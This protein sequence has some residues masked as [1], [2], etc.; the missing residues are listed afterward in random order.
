MPL[1]VRLV[2]ILKRMTLYGLVLGG[3]SGFLVTLTILLVPA[4]DRPTFYGLPLDT[5]TIILGGV[6][7]GVLFGTIAGFTSGFGM[8]LFTALLFREVNDM[9]RFRLMMGS[10]TL[11]L[12]VAT[13]VGRGLW[14]FGT[15]VIDPTTWQVTMVMSVLIAMYASQRVA[16]KYL[17]ELN[18]EKV[19]HSGVSADE[20]TGLC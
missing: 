19:K 13:L 17:L 5:A 18:P 10:T 3:A 14:D 15:L 1:V 6:F 9:M 12:T 7:F 4:L 11:M 2:G 20:H 8:A 16:T